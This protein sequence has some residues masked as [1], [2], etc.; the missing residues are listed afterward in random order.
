MLSSARVPS[1]SSNI[2][3][4]ARFY[5]ENGYWIGKGLLD[6]G[7]VLATRDEMHQIFKQQLHYLRL[8]S[9]RKAGEDA[10]HEDMAALLRADKDRYLASLRLCA[11]VT[12]LTALYLAPRLR[13]FSEAIGISLPVF[14]TNPVFHVISEDLRIP[15]GYY[16]YGIH[17]DWP[18]LQSGLDT[19][20]LW[21]PFVS[22]DEL[23]YTLDI[24]PGSHLRGLLPGKMEQNAFEVDP[25]SYREE[26]FV[27]V[28]ADPGD[29]L[30]M[31]CFLVHRSSLKG[32]R[33]VRIACS[34]RYENAS[35]A[36][37]VAHSYPFV[38][39]RVVQR[40]FLFQDLPTAEQVRR[41]FSS[42]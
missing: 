34:M 33:R 26:D 35:E 21:V 42:S 5:K 10:M 17:Q 32:G 1:E 9:S 6:V 41:V 3:A 14:Q 25:A 27:S 8:G 4:G 11:K 28:K 22:V 12:S 7:E 39:K 2:D 13:R 19:V 29:V 40:E 23:N 30:F 18:A 31:S 15:G 36:T 38:H 16:G 37:F 24:L 20:T